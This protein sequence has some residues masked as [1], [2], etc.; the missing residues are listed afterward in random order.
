MEEHDRY[1][2]DRDEDS[3]KW[4]GGSKLT[5]AVSL[6][7]LPIGVI[8]GQLSGR[9]EEY[10]SRMKSSQRESSSGTK[11]E[12]GSDEESESLPTVDEEGYESELELEIQEA[13]E[14]KQSEDA[15]N[16]NAAVKQLV[17]EVYE[18]NEA[19]FVES[20]QENR[21]IRISIWDYGKPRICY[22]DTAI[23]F[24]PTSLIFRWTDGL[25]ITSPPLPSL[26]MECISSSSA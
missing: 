25:S 26:V 6:Q 17:E 1:T 18:Y 22:I 5:K 10:K 12:E 16:K 14:E 21:A 23:L 15:I 13:T 24:P 9:A 2:T 20:Q 7:K 3:R 4:W 19:L 11:S 8:A